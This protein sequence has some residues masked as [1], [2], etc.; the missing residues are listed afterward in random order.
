MQVVVDRHMDS[1][2]NLPS[3]HNHLDL[4]GLRRLVDT[5]ETNIAGLKALEES[6]DSYGGVVTS[7]VMGRL[8]TEIRLMVGRGC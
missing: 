5:V 4:E 8:P 3:V 1:L 2:M 6:E 7:V